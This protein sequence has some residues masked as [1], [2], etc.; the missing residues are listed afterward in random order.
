MLLKSIEDPK[1]LSGVLYSSVFT[2]SE[3]KQKFKKF[4]NSFKI[5][6]MGLLL[7]T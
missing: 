7:L 3:L 6:R 4:I 1:E 2:V 5:T